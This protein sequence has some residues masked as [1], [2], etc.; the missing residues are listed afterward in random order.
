MAAPAVEESPAADTTG[1][2]AANASGVEVDTV[3]GSV[4]PPWSAAKPHV[5]LY[6]H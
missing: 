4:V 5:K 3:R 6:T 1:D 2:A